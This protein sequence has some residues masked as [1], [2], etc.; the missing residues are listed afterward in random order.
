MRIKKV[1]SK[2]VQILF[3]LLLGGA[4]LGWMYQDFNFN[5]VW[6]VLTNGMNYGWMLATLLFG[7]FSNLFRSWRWKL[8]LEPLNENPSTANCIYAVFIAY[9]TNLIIPRLGEVS[10]CVI[11]SKYS[12]TSFSKSLGTVVS[13]R[14]IDTLCVGAITLITLVSQSHVFASFFQVTG[15]NTDAWIDLFTSAN[16][17]IV[18]ICIIAFFTLIYFV[19]RNVGTFAKLRG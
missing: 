19:I 9:A 3:P 1:V 8:S 6:Q 15:T 11:L 10:R 17:Y 13:E 7:V 18:V 14:L 16:F 5:R 12:G 2:T 4:I